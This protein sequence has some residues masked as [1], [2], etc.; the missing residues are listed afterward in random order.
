MGKKSFFGW[1]VGSGIKNSAAQT[2]K[3]T[4][5]TGKIV[6]KGAKKYAPQVALAVRT[7][8]RKAKS[9]YGGG[10]TF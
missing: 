8:A 1:V 9:L 3:V 7:K 4:K 5:Q 10:F 2:Q 6:I